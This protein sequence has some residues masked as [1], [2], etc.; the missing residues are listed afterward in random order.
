MYAT[1][2]H[3]VRGAWDA[4]LLVARGEDSRSN[5]SH[6]LIFRP[7]LYDVDQTTP[8]VLATHHRQSLLSL[9]TCHSALAVTDR[10]CDPS[11]RRPHPPRRP[12]RSGPTPHEHLPPGSLEHIPKRPLESP[13]P[14]LPSIL[15]SLSFRT[16]HPLPL[17]QPRRPLPRSDSHEM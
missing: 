16:A 1:G 7:T 9:P 15:N 17:T 14:S 11:S 2:Y 5:F 4:L 13:T 12:P 3:N 6:F 10:S 8:L